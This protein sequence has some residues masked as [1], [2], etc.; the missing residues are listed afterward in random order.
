MALGPG[1]IERRDL[2]LFGGRVAGRDGS[3]AGG[4]F[5]TAARKRLADSTT[6]RPHDLGGLEESLGCCFRLG[7]N[8][9][10][11]LTRPR[12]ADDLYRNTVVGFSRQTP[13]RTLVDLSAAIVANGQLDACSLRPATFRIR[14]GRTRVTIGVCRALRASSPCQTWFELQ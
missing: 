2:D 12:S 1:G 8:R 7:G 9:D 10:V 14:I 4:L 11:G 13:S 6:G 5:C 3:T